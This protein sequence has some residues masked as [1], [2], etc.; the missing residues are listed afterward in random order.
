MLR[1]KHGSGG[2]A[3]AL[4]AVENEFFSSIKYNFSQMFVGNIYGI[5]DVGLSVFFGGAQVYQNC[6]RIMGHLIP[7]FW[8]DD[9]Y[10]NVHVKCPFL[11]WYA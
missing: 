9:L 2:A 10:G 4:P 7:L 1:Q 6:V 3:D 11:L 8:G 5:G